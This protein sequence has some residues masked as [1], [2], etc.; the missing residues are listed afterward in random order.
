LSH[1]TFSLLV[2]EI[3]DAGVSDIVEALKVNN[4]LNGITFYCE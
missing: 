1:S 4:T 3:G 2:N